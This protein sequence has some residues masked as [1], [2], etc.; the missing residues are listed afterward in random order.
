VKILCR[1]RAG[2]IEHHNADREDR[3]GLADEVSGAGRHHQGGREVGAMRN[4]AFLP[5]IFELLLRSWERLVL[6][7]AA[8]H[9]S[10]RD[11][12]A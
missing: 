9:D 1:Q 2:L 6:V 11:K 10:A 8:R 3:A 12:A 5:R 4:L 7:A